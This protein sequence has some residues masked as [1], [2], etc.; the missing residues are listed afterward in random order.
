LNKSLIK[1]RNNLIL[2]RLKLLFE[3]IKKP[4]EI[5]PIEEKGK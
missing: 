1:K 5:E 4:V 2:E 3:E